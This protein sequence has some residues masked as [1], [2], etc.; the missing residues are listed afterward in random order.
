MSRLVLHYDVVSPWS[1]VAF[2]T[3]SLYSSHWSIPLELHPIN[4]GRVMKEAGNQPPITVQN[5]GKWMW[6]EMERCSDFFGVKLSTPQEFPFNSFPLQCFLRVVERDHP[7]CLHS[8]TT[9]FYQKVW[10][11]NATFA[12]LTAIGNVLAGEAGANSGLSGEQLQEV[13][14]EA[15]KKETRTMMNDEAAKLVREGGAFGAP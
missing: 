9:F 15:G 8:L 6:K 12:D 7:G 2:H 11:D 13:L 10:E 1:K 3:L 4:L 5:K 14:A